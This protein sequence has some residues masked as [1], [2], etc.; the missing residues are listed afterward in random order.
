MRHMN[1]QLHKIH[2]YFFEVVNQGSIT[3]AA[4]KLYVSQPSLTKFIQRLENQL[5]VKLFDRSVLPIRLTPAGELYR[6]YLEKIAAI[7]AEFSSNLAK[8]RTDNSG[9]IIFSCSSWRASLRIP[10]ILSA[11]GKAYPNIEVVLLEVAHPDICSV[12]RDGRADIGFTSSLALDEGLAFHRLI[13]EP[14]FLVVNVDNP[15]LEQVS[16]RYLPGDPIGCVDI[17]EFENERFIVL[18][19]NQMLRL[20]TEDLFERNK[21]KPK[22]FETSSLNTAMGIVASGDGVSFLPAEGRATLRDAERFRLLYIDSP[23][24]CWEMGLLYNAHL[25][26]SKQAELFFHFIENYYGQFLSRSSD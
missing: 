22:L 7:D 4:E 2:R 15:I 11:F 17:Q 5:S 19:S 25:G 24:L 21:M 20:F 26:M 16:I 1:E 23:P 6:D 14:I 3:L 10:Q 18:R 9:K 13:T 12:I 8:L